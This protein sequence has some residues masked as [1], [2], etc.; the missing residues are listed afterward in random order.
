MTQ[1]KK[2]GKENWAERT[3]Y[4]RSQNPFDFQI[5]EEKSAYGAQKPFSVYYNDLEHSIRL[6]K[7]DCIDILKL[8]RENSVDMIF[9][10]PPYFLSNGGIT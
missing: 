9:A 10:D 2:K 7:G 3:Q 1:E 6:L 4:V 8:A 5:A